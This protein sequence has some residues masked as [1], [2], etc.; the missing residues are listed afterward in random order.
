MNSYTQTT[1]TFSSHE[2]YQ[3]DR[4]GVVGHNRGQVSPFHLALPTQLDQPHD[5]ENANSSWVLKPRIS[6]SFGDFESST[7]LY[8]RPLTPNSGVSVR[9][10]PRWCNTDIIPRALDHEF[11]AHSTNS[12]DENLSPT[13]PYSTAGGSPQLSSTRGVL[14]PRTNLPPLNLDV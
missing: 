1:N 14:T 13:F 8:Q 9:T 5:D 11:L 3:D 7:S 2:S 12:N 6:N 10:P 4:A